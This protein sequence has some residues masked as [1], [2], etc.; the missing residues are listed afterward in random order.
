M[1]G[2]RKKSPFHDI[3][4][5][6]EAADY[7]AAEL[8]RLMALPLS[9]KSDVEQWYSERDKTQQALKERFPRFEF[10]HEVWHFFADADI[11]AR[12][13]GYRDRQHRR[14]SD[15]VTFLRREPPNACQSASANRASP[16]R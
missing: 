1:F 8:E 7:I 16:R 5:T 4:R 15:Y 3:G 10:W 14:M 9:T 12:D 6:R 2:K 13:T 11:R